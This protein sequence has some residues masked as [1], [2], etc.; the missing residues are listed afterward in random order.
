MKYLKIVLLAMFLHHSPSMQCTIF[1][2]EELYH[3]RLRQTVIL[4]GDFHSEK[5]LDVDKQ[6]LESIEK[7][8][9]KYNPF[10]FIEED[11]KSEANALLLEK[12]PHL[13]EKNQF[14]YKCIDFRK[15]IGLLLYYRRQ[16]LEE[17]KAVIRDIA[18]EWNNDPQKQKMATFMQG[19]LSDAWEVLQKLIDYQASLIFEDRTLHKP[20]IEILDNVRWHAGKISTIAKVLE[21]LKQ[22]E[23]DNLIDFL[24]TNIFIEGNKSGV[25]KDSIF[26]MTFEVTSEIFDLVIVTEIY[27]KSLN[28]AIFVVAGQKHTESVSK[29]LQ[30]L[31][32][33]SKNRTTD[34]NT[35]G[36]DDFLKNIDTYGETSPVLQD[37]WTRIDDFFARCDS[38]NRQ[39]SSK[40]F[41]GFI[42]GTCITVG[43]IALCAKYNI[44]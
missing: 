24:T 10:V 9:K 4:M 34:C 38:L 2:M 39:P 36:R 35:N 33:I 21:G 40:F 7:A 28:R 13:C 22:N 17:K 27:K 42:T 19:A 5:L 43:C 16:A 30:K 12:L 32:Y 23:Q 20:M 25:K 31:G 8:I 6:Q 29:M 1:D 15:I 44:I 18:N 14:S 3:P 41:S 37:K 11:K 26:Q